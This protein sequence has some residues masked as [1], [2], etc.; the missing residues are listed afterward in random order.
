M[1][2]LT[3]A[4]HSCSIGAKL[5]SNGTIQDSQWLTLS[6]PTHNQRG[7]RGR[8]PKANPEQTHTKVCMTD[9]AEAQDRTD[10]TLIIIYTRYKPKE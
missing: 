4:N 7:R 10:T 2:I 1:T 6:L 9:S 5:S 8:E 3:L